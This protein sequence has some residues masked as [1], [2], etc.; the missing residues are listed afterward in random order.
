MQIRMVR[1][2][3]YDLGLIFQTSSFDLDDGDTAGKF[4]F[5][6]VQDAEPGD[7]LVRITAS[8]DDVRAVTHR[9]ITI[10]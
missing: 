9:Y 2:Y 6:N 1:M 10:I 5:W 4:L 7:Y 8:N 3:I